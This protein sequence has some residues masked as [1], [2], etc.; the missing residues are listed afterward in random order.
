MKIS[1]WWER[2]L[3]LSPALPSATITERFSFD[4]VLGEVGI[5]ISFIY[6]KSL[7]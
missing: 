7:L 3:R 4:M 2:G 1:K 5:T 6:F